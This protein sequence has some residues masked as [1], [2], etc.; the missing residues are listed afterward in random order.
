MRN[1]SG[2]VIHRIT[3][4]FDV[5]AVVPYEVERTGPTRIY[6]PSSYRMDF[7]IWFN[8]DFSGSV[9]EAVPKSFTILNHTF[10]RENS[11]AGT[12]GRK[13]LSA[14]ITAK[15]GEAI[16]LSYEFDAPDAAARELI[17]DISVEHE[18]AEHL[19][20]DGECG[21]GRGMVVAAKVAAKPDERGGSSGQGLCGRVI[22]GTIVKGAPRVYNR[23]DAACNK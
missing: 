16:T 19:A 6:P 2:Q 13:T 21:M 14:D 23:R 7:S 22:S 15:A 10:S 12:D 1:E 17:Q 20:V 11:E 5:R 18:C 9:V 3:D 8:E 4:S